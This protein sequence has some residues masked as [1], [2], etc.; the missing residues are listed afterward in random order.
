MVF[1]IDNTYIDEEIITGVKDK[2]NVL[3]Y[4][5]GYYD[6]GTCLKEELKELIKEHYR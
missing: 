1:K 6:G 2:D 4:Y 5:G 3:H